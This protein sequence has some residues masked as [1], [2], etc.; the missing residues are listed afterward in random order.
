MQVL[1]DSAVSKRHLSPELLARCLSQEPARLFGLYGRKGAV[2]VGFDA[3]IV[4]FDPE[5]EWEIT[6]DSLFYLNKISAFVGLKGKGRPV[7]TFV[8]GEPVFRD[9]GGRKHE[10]ISPPVHGRL[11]LGGSGFKKRR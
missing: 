3:D 1:Y 7:M 2:E 11:E 9:D 4:V 8:R 6:P 10:K 5:R